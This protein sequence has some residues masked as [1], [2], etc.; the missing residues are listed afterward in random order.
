VCTIITQAKL[1]N[2]SPCT[3]VNDSDGAGPQCKI[4]R[5][6]L[7]AEKANR[8]CSLRLTTK[9]KVMKHEYQNVIQYKV[10][11]KLIKFIM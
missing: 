4:F 2:R 10:K 3:Q 11:E 6:L 1:K 8:I 5:P 7:T 9:K